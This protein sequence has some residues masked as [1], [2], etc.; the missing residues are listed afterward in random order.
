M[1][2]DEQEELEYLRL[3]KRK[4]LAGNMALPKDA[5]AAGIN[6]PQETSGGDTNSFG[7]HTP[8]AVNSA[9]TETMPGRFMSGMGSEIVNMGRGALQSGVEG[10]R[11]LVDPVSA[12]DNYNGVTSAK[13]KPTP[14]LKTL[15]QPLDRAEEG[16]QKGVD[17]TRA[18]QDSLGMSGKAGAITA[19]LL[20]YAVAPESIPGQLATG[21]AQGATAPRGTDEDFSRLNSGAEQG[22][23]NA[24][25]AVVA[26][27][28]VAPFARGVRTPM[29]NAPHAVPAG[30]VNEAMGKIGSIVQDQHTASNEALQQ[31]FRPLIGPQKATPMNAEI[32]RTTWIP[33]IKK[34][35]ENAAFDPSDKPYTARILKR[36]D[37]MLDAKKD[38]TLRQF[39]GL[40]TQMV[41]LIDQGTDPIKGMSKDAVLL[42]R[43]KNL[44]DSHLNFLLDRGLFEGDAGAL[45][46]LKNARALRTEHGRRFEDSDVTARIVGKQNLTP[47][48]LLNATL[49]ANQAVNKA[50][51][52]RVFD[53][54]VKAAG[55]QG[56]E[57]KQLYKT[58]VLHKFMRDAPDAT[59][60][61]L[62]ARKLQRAVNLFIKQNPTLANKVF[63][64]REVVALRQMAAKGNLQAAADFFG[65]HFAAAAFGATGGMAGAAGGPAGIGMGAAL[66]YG[67]PASIRMGTQKFVGNSINRGMQDILTGATEA[68]QRPT[69]IFERVGQ[70]IGNKLRNR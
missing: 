51:S 1:A 7:F 31:A 10:I 38:P 37:G 4:A 14:G 48:E 20:P 64:P 70:R 18:V 39:E 62:D 43:V 6:V 2:L 30:S 3:K 69:N 46:D 40:R 8:D 47:E 59:G 63:T 41:D 25:G 26:N 11:T 53:D 29:P 15:T 54:L 60:N 65:N 57:V 21:F 52:G 61:G 27:K 44:Y 67:I 49:G 32:A 12:V 9:L 66:G 58:A 35:L 68:A 22:L 33:E 36:L 19:D 55:N 56:E 5:Q 13:G 23:L 16:L 50:S 24:G 42:N 45:S 17:K 28:V 34:E